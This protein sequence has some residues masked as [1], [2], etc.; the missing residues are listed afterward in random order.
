[1][2]INIQTRAGQAGGTTRDA[3]AKG[4]CDLFLKLF[5][6]EILTRFAEYNVMKDLTMVR[7]ISSGKSA[8]FP[9]TGVAEAAYH[10]PGESVISATKLSNIQ[11]NEKV[12][13]IDDLLVSSVLIANIDELRNHYDLRSIYADELGKA[14]ANTCDKN[15]IK[16][17][18]AAARTGA[19]APALAGTTIDGG[20]F[21]NVA[22]IITALFNCAATLDEKDVPSEGRFAVMSPTEYYKLLTSDNVAISKDTTNGSADAAK[23]TIVEVAGLRLYKSNHIKDVD[24]LADD[25]A[26]TTAG[27]NN[28]VFGSSGIGYNGNFASFSDGTTY[29]KGCGFIAGHGSA[30]GTV[31]LLDLATESDYL[32]ERQA[33]LFAAKYAMG[34]G[35]LRPESA[36]EVQTS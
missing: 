29:A 24:G 31:K 22:N 20:D 32:V 8:Q 23:G 9:V 34:H 15:I 13:H 12:I 4:D 17:F 5:S 18:I 28:D 16:T 2:P 14:L 21:S 3:A 6:G 26:I 1:M 27:E 7:S 33:T 19:D 30:V 36:I 25:S 11:H 35:V 10:V